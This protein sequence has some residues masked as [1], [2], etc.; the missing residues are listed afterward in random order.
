M[1]STLYQSAAPD[2]FIAPW[3]TR[4]IEFLIAIIEIMLTIAKNA[5]LP[6]H[7]LR[8]GCRKTERW[9][10][11]LLGAFLPDDGE[12][13][14]HG[15]PGGRRLPSVSLVHAH[16]QPDACSCQY[17]D[18]DIGRQQPQAGSLKITRKKRLANCLHVNFCAGGADL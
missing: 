5:R 10:S 14:D 16:R 6:W 11:V 12:A 2:R 15:R 9:L 4:I 3:A 1:S 7:E 17:G 18:V 13:R 8:T